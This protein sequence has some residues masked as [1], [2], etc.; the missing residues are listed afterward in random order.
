MD[1]AGHLRRERWHAD[2]WFPVS[3]HPSENAQ[4]SSFTW[5]DSD[6]EVLVLDVLL[7]VNVYS[8][9]IQVFCVWQSLFFF[10]QFAIIHFPQKGWIQT[11]SGYSGCS[12]YILAICSPVIY[13]ESPLSSDTRP[14]EKI[15]ISQAF[16]CPFVSHQLSTYLFSHIFC[17]KNYRHK[18][19]AHFYPNFQFFVSL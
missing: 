13:C 19:E 15:M 10:F 17:N 18:K 8:D 1:E 3:K 16:S 4:M 12:H 9:F 11:Y 2:K 14:T 7:E 6:C 5:S